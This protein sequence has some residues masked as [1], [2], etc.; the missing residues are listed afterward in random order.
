MEQKRDLG[1]HAIAGAH[2]VQLGM[3]LPKQKCPRLLGFALRRADDTGGEK[4]WLLGYT[5][6]ASA[7]P[8]HTSGFFVRPE[9]GNSE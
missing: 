6:F 5:I 2:A 8:S 1:L 7:E 4:H 3:D 9:R